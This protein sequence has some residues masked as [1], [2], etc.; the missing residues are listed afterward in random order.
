MREAKDAS[1]CCRV[2]GSKMSQNGCMFAREASEVK[3]WPA[4]VFEYLIVQ[5]PHRPFIPFVLHLFLNQTVRA[6][7]VGEEL[8][9]RAVPGLVPVHCMFWLLFRTT[10]P[11]ACDNKQQA[12]L[13]PF[14]LNMRL[15]FSDRMYDGMAFRSA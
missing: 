15:S 14:N 13:S 4:R 2:D 3:R 5:V 11:S 6:E 12:F 9:L 10:Q 7:M 1:G 8:R